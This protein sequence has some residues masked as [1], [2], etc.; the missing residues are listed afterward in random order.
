MRRPR[1]VQLG[2]LN[3]LLLFKIFCFF[4]HASRSEHRSE[5]SLIVIK[6]LIPITASR[7][8]F[9]AMI[10]LIYDL[11]CHYFFGLRRR[12]KKIFPPHGC[13]TQPCYN[14]KNNEVM[15]GK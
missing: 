1:N 8:H 5:E 7:T 11:L 2:R 14:A 13:M 12:A 4:R 10:R 3:I 6:L 9:P 15:E